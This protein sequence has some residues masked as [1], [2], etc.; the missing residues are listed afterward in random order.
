M[1]EEWVSERIPSEGTDAELND[2]EFLGWV[3]HFEV[4]D[5]VAVELQR[6]SPRSTRH[7]SHLE[8]YRHEISCLYMRTQIIKRRLEVRSRHVLQRESLRRR[9]SSGYLRRRREA[10]TNQSTGEGS[11]GPSLVPPHFFERRKWQLAP[12]F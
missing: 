5:V 6:V 4:S 11:Q 9:R 2:C 8:V 7:A 1:R 3:F 12:L 10:W